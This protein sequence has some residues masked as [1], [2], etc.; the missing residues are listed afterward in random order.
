M[1][2]SKVDK[3]DAKADKGKETKVAA[4]GGAS[5][6]KKKSWTKVKIKE[7]LNNAVYLDQKAY[8]RA[9][10]EAPKFLVITVSELC[11]KFKVNGA[12]ART[13]IRD[14]HSKGLIR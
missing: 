7:K 13:L 3:K 5:K 2:V 10:K 8:D 11:N 14:L 6:T 1:V 9:V 4:K 12:V